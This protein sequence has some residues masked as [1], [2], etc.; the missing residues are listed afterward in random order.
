MPFSLLTAIIAIS[1][2]IHR[3]RCFPYGQSVNKSTAYGGYICH[4]QAM[5][6]Q[7]QR[8][9]SHEA[10]HCRIDIPI[11]FS[12][13][14]HIMAVRHTILDSRLIRVLCPLKQ[15]KR[16]LKTTTSPPPPNLQPSSS[17]GSASIDNDQV[18]R[19]ASK[20]LHPL[21]L[22]DLVR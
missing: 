16:H 11:S 19:L 15:P 18:A 22:A 3:D 9:S 17:L 5:V 2:T 1:I 6:E 7:A 4:V 8:R 12:A 10:Y 20:P 21:S 13:P 14:T